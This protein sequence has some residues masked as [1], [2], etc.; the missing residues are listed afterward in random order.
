MA[1]IDEICEK[2][3]HSLNLLSAI[4]VRYYLPRNSAGSSEDCRALAPAE[5]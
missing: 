2:F 5:Y 1:E 3:I 4:E